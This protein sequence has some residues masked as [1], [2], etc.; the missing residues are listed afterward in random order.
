MAKTFTEEEVEE[1]ASEICD[2][3]CIY[4]LKLQA[5]ETTCKDCPFNKLFE[6]EGG[7]NGEF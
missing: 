6:E 1:V 3:Y 2:K 4:S 5:G 7:S